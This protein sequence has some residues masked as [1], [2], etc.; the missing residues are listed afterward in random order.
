MRIPYYIAIPSCFLIILIVWWAS[1]RNIDFLTPPSATELE[2]IHRK[3]IASLPISKVQTQVT[4]AVPAA[5]TSTEP[6]ASE[7]TLIYSGAVDIGE[8]SR[9]KDLDT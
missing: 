4:K 6:S 8:L 9:P 2:N 7:P 5:V 1:T 3:T